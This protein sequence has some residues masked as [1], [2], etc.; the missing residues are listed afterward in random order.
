MT[1]HAHSDGTSRREQPMIDRARVTRPQVPR[2]TQPCTCVRSTADAAQ[3]WPESQEPRPSSR[4]G[5]LA[6]RAEQ[7]PSRRLARRPLAQRVSQIITA[8]VR[9]AAIPGD[10]RSLRGCDVCEI[11]TAVVRHA[12]ISGDPRNLRGCD[13]CEIIT[14]GLADTGSAYYATDASDSGLPRRTRCRTWEG[15]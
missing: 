14:A 15:A 13:V 9:H 12:A 6:R 2:V 10:P 1:A 11:I 5:R 4:F 8:V 3:S 7:P